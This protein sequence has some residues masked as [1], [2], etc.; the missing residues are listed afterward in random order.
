MDVKFIEK[1]KRMAVL[2]E[3][4]EINYSFPAQFKLH[5]HTYKLLI[6]ICQG[7]VYKL[8]HCRDGKIEYLT[9]L[10]DKLGFINYQDCTATLNDN[11]STHFWIVSDNICLSIFPVLKPTFIV[12][13]CNSLLLL[14]KPIHC[15]LGKIVTIFQYSPVDEE[16]MKQ[17]KTSVK[18]PVLKK[19]SE[20][21]RRN[22]LIKT[23][24]SEGSNLVKL[25][26]MNPMDMID[27]SWLTI[28]GNSR[29]YHF[30][31]PHLQSQFTGFTTSL[32]S[33]GY[34]DYIIKNYY[35][36]NCE[37]IL[38]IHEYP[39][40]MGERPYDIDTVIIQGPP[41]DIH[42]TS[43]IQTTLCGSKMRYLTDDKWS[44]WENVQVLKDALSLQNFW[45]HILKKAPQEPY[46]IFPKN[47]S[48]FVPIKTIRKEPL[49]FYQ[50]IF[51]YYTKKGRQICHYLDRS[52]YEIFKQT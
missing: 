2:C 29:L 1:L 9:L 26:K 33:I 7:N 4:Q 16:F 46:L 52:W 49:S 18:H 37:A 44:D 32:S 3:S 41:S 12:G 43:D 30:L 38:F 45:V 31:P 40:Q 36:E 48:Y 8:K 21:S 34:L 19:T 11:P 25:H 22:T 5:I 14:K 28:V 17:F 50:G 13:V 10:N 15:A 35:R 51:N 39:L 6:E 24:P 42:C 23:S 27:L 47:N 20:Q